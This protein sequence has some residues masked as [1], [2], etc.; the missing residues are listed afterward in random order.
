MIKYAAL[1]FLLIGKLAMA[2]QTVSDLTAEESRRLD[3]QRA[4]VTR[5]L[6]DASVENYK[7]PAGK[8]G[9]LRALL[10]A[11]MFRA[12][13][14]R[15]LRAMG[16][17]LGDVFVQDMQFHW[18][19]VQDEYG[20]DPAIKYKDTSVMLFPLTMISKRVEAGEEVDV[21]ALY[22]GLAERAASIIES[23]ARR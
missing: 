21:F 12:D 4:I 13:Q 8:L 10:Q 2:E 14:T 22:N 18:V 20:R 19:M 16:V 5:H 23:E 9:T 6:A 15:E 7:T 3:E 11:K 1:F 17:V